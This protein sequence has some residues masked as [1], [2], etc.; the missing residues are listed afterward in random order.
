MFVLLYIANL[1]NEQ[2]SFPK[3]QGK[4]SSNQEMQSMILLEKD[5]VYHNNS[6][7]VYTIIIVFNILEVYGINTGFGKFKDEVIDQDK[8]KSV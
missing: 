5:K 7:I 4:R 3:Q 1:F 2:L 8:V 6:T